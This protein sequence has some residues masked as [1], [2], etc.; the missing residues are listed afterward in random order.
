MAAKFAQAQVPR[1][2][3]FAGARWLDRKNIVVN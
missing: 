2:H 3:Q 1:E